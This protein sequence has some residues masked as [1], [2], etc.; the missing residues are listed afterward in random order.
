MGGNQACWRFPALAVRR[1]CFTPQSG[2]AAAGL[3]E[4]ALC[5]NR[6]LAGVTRSP[7]RRSRAA[8]AHGEAEH[9]GGVS[10]DDQLELDA[11]TTGRSAGSR[12]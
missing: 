7:G 8:S 1:V 12:P 3:G 6:S 10:V 2:H 9:P 5:H 4:T 11:C